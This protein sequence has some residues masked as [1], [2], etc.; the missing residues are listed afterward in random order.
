MN[1]LLPPTKNAELISTVHRP[2]RM[3]LAQF[4]TYEVTE[5]EQTCRNL[6]YS[7]EEKL[8]TDPNSFVNEAEDCKP[9]HRFVAG[10]YHRELYIPPNRVIVGKRHAVEH[11]V[12]L[13]QGS[14]TCVTERGYEEMVAPL[15]FISPAGEK[16]VVITGPDQDCTWVTLHPTMETN[17][18]KIEE[19]VIIAEPEREERYLAIRQQAKELSMN[20]NFNLEASVQEPMVA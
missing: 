1:E 20:K 4:E 13:T 2:K 19:D 3:T 15:T 11:V 10:L 12:M 16:R 5:R 6:I 8:H 9:V 7:L 18:E 14:C 17:L